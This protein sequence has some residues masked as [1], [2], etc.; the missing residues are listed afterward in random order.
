MSYP[1]DV[2]A[3]VVGA[4]GGRLGGRHLGKMNILV[5]EFCV[6]LAPTSSLLYFSEK[7]KGFDFPFSTLYP[8]SSV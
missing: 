1:K 6:H 4:R 2:I 3:S 8:A 7:A 5:L